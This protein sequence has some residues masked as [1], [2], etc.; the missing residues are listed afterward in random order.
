MSGMFIYRYHGQFLSIAG[1]DTVSSILSKI[2]LITHEH[3]GNILLG[4]ILE[5]KKK[6][7]KKVKT[8]TNKMEKVYYRKPQ[9]CK[10]VAA[11]RLQKLCV[12]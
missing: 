4:H 6:E 11:W 9:Y 7:K 10:I 3:D 12:K 8:G 1:R 5:C 2:T